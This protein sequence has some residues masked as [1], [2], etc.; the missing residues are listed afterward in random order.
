MSGGQLISETEHLTGGFPYIVTCYQ[1]YCV[2][3]FLILC[4]KKVFVSP[5]FLLKGAMSDHIDQQCWDAFNSGVEDEVIQLLD[6]VHNPSRIT[7]SY[8]WTLVHLAASRGLINVLKR[9]IE[10]YHCDPNCETKQGSI[11]LHLA[12]YNGHLDTVKYLTKECQCDPMHRNKKHCTPLD[13]TSRFRHISVVEYLLSTGKVY[14]VR[15]SEIESVRSSSRTYNTELNKQIIS[16]GGISTSS[17]L[18]LYTNIFI[19]GNS[20]VGKSTLA[21]VIIER[22][23]D[24]PIFGR[25]RNIKGVKRYTAGIISHKL[26]HKELGNIILH[27]F[28]GH[29]H[30]HFS[31]IAVLENLLQNSAAVF[32]IVI[33]ICDREASTHLKQWQMFIKNLRSE[34]AHR[35]IVVASHI[36]CI[37]ASE[38]RARYKQLLQC[39]DSKDSMFS[40]LVTLN[41]R[42]L[43]GDKLVSFIKI[44]S[45]E[46]DLIRNNF[47]TRKMNLYCHLLYPFLQQKRK[48]VYTLEEL[49]ISYTKEDYSLMDK[50]DQKRIIKLLPDLH[51][52]G[53]IMF[54]G[55]D[56]TPLNSWV[57][58]DKNILLHEVNGT[59]FAP[60]TFKEHR[61][62]FSNTGVITQSSLSQL[63]P[64]YPKELLCQFLVSLE[65]CIDISSD[66]DR[67]VGDD[68]KLFFFPALTTTSGRPEENDTKYQFGWCL[69][70]TADCDFLT[71]YFFHVLLMQL[72]FNHALP[73]DNAPIDNA[74]QKLILNR[75]CTVY[76]NGIRWLRNGVTTL[77]ELVD[78]N[79]C[80]ILFISC[81]EGSEINMMDR[82]Y[83]IIQNILILHKQHCSTIS[84]K[85]FLI[86]CSEVKLPI[87]TSSQLTLYD[88]HVLACQ[89]KSEPHL[90][91][92]TSETLK[93]KKVSDL[94]PF[95]PIESGTCSLSIFGGR[96]LEV[97]EWMSLLYIFKLVILLY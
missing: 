24:S 63:F 43:D 50:R 66:I 30:Y 87:N 76:R 16:M 9:L 17:F 93:E 31:H 21:Q 79:R 78:D 91:Y 74:K 39:I 62:V 25:F 81:K 55:N 57:V 22:C 92:I 84:V 61:H 8:N 94:L 2:V 47:T 51:S 83:K 89:I 68:E 3:K 96:R 26:E 52:T 33:N 7:D 45:N 35:V 5:L 44:L 38:S 86:D 28:A 6:Q 53:L 58:A 90:V 48:S 29:S 15:T 10:E 97:C 20:G 41:C 67:N 95:E 34:N 42:K 37:P 12:C 46:C 19:L 88:V 75:T 32:I 14:P 36:D 23:R 11:P 65:L 60:E 82:R 70:C 56:E 1:V 54:F 4:A 72:A 18:N 64:Y 71:S 85:E 69:K 80:V 40:D 27:D 13:Y 73:I 59:L 77:V 49:I